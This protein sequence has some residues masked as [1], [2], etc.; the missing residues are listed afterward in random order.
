MHHRGLVVVN[1]Y[2]VLPSI[3]H[4]IDRM[5]FEFKNLDIELD[6][7]NTAEI[8]AFIGSDG[9]LYSVDLPYDF[10]LFLDK[11]R[12]ISHLLEESGM[13]LFNSARA[14]EACDDKMLTYMNLMHFGIHMP[15]TV[16][17]P[18]HY[19]LL[20]NED[21]LNN[22]VNVIPFP[23]VVKTNYGSQGQGVFL[24][25]NMDELREIESQITYRPRLYQE[26]I[27]ASKGFD[28]RLIIVGGKFVAG[29]K[30]RSITGDFRSNLSVGGIGVEHTMSPFQIDTAERIARAMKLD[31]CGID[32]LESG[33]REEPILCEVNSNAFFK[34]AE[35][36]TGINV[37]EKYAAHIFNEIYRVK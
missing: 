32:F 1:A 9:E 24:A 34:G 3:Q 27:E 20:D 36:V 25:N 11:D 4:F 28:Y 6:V 17:G 37:A 31:Y 22:L 16:T 26:F 2:D 21:F 12:Y 7:K 18:L 13:R 30:R 5:A 14:I 35:E 8:Y 33:I 15:K 19:S 29:Y 23:I 10:V